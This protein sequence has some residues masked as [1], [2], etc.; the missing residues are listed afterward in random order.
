MP[1]PGNLLGDCVLRF[2]RSDIAED[3]DSAA[4]PDAQLT[5]SRTG[6]VLGYVR[7][8]AGPGADDPVAASAEVI[9]PSPAGVGR[10]V[11]VSRPA[12]VLASESLDL[13]LLLRLRGP[14]TEGGSRSRRYSRGL[15]ALLC[16][17]ALLAPPLPQAFRFV[18]DSHDAILTRA[19]PIDRNTVDQSLRDGR[20]PLDRRRGRCSRSAGRRRGR[21]CSRRR[22]Q[23][24]NPPLVAAGLMPLHASDRTRA[25]RADHRRTSAQISGTSQARRRL[26]AHLLLVVHIRSIIE[27]KRQTAGRARVPRIAAAPVTFRPVATRVLCAACAGGRRSRTIPSRSGPERRA[28][29]PWPA[30]R[31]AG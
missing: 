14:R 18:V 20:R 19:A 30:R 16:Q 31:P 26:A 29:T 11:V 4:A 17:R 27:R 1:V 28:R 12:P 3:D 22:R 13:C 15:L 7:R 6:L 9:P 25:R 5:W 21:G 23:L 24:A 2:R 10:N 8:I